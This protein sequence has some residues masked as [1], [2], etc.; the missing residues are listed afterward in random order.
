MAPLRLLLLLPVAEGLQAELQHPLGL[1]FL[2]R[3]EP[4]D[5]LVQSFL[6]NLCMYIGGKA[7]LIL[8]L[9]HLTHKF[10]LFFHEFSFGVQNYE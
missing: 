4:D 8:L 3:D 6:Y 9:G 7:K 1:T 2:L 5:V 10:I